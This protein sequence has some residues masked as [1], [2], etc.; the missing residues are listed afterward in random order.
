MSMIAV[1]RQILETDRH[2]INDVD[3]P[4]GRALDLED[5]SDAA[6]GRLTK[7]LRAI[8]SGA[9]RW[10]GRFLAALHDSR[11]NRAAIEIARFR[12]LIHDPDNGISSRT[13]STTQRPTPAE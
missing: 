9:S 3:T 6:I 10:C 8:A 5:R 12:D 7:I 1:S 13:N 4:R 11:R 2:A